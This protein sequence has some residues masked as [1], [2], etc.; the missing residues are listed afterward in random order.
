VSENRCIVSWYMLKPYTLDRNSC[1]Y[2]KFK[3]NVDYIIILIFNTSA[4][5]STNSMLVDYVVDRI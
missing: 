1:F 5:S 4:A 3:L 2:I